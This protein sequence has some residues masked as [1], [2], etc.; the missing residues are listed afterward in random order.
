[1]LETLLH[2]ALT[3]LVVLAGVQDWRRREVTDWLTWPLFVMGLGSAVF[4]ATHLD[5]LSLLVGAFLLV[6]WYFDWL[7]GAD[8]RILIGLLGVWPMAGLLGMVCTGMWGLV[9]VLR[10]RGRDRIPALVTVAAATFI[11]FLVE[12]FR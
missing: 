3:T 5:F 8:A 2:L 4:R 1:M 10:R 9:L 7:G 6:T 12:L 11:E